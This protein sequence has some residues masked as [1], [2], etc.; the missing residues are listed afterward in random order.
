MALT[1]QQLIE[2]RNFIGGSDAAAALG[3]SKWKTPYQ[4]W[5]EKL[6][7]AEPQ[8]ET[9]E[10]LR[11]SALEPALR[12]HYANETGYTVELPTKALVSE[13][14]PFMSYNPDGLVMAAKRL[15]EFK[16]AAYG[17]GWGEVG[18]DEVPQEYLLQCQHGMIVTN[19]EV[20]DITVSIAGNKP[21]CFVIEFDKELAEMIIDG[22][23]KFWDMVKNRIAPEPINNDDVVKIYKHI[24]GEY[25]IADDIISGMVFDLKRARESLKEF[26][27]TK[28]SLEVK[29]KQYMGE[30]NAESLVD[31]NG[32]A[33]CTWKNAKGAAR[34]DSDRLK[35]EQPLIA[36]Q[37]TKI[38]EP[39]RRFLLK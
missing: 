25:C 20:T 28:E 39:S 21:K 12:Q 32:V 8:E 6:G 23:A 16:T 13:K 17:Q 34:I 36:A 24:N 1:Q 7:E 29:I 2:R 37:Y 35:K 9:W 31:V 3:V 33:L 5:Q 19:L 15:A 30:N 27:A 22:E 11:G 10:M 26:E 14:Y 4:L 38:G 18:S